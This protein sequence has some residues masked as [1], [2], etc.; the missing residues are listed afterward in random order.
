MIRGENAQ[1]AWQE[2]NFSCHGPTYRNLKRNASR[3]DLLTSLNEISPILSG[4]ADGIHH[5]TVERASRLAGGIERTAEGLH[6]SG[7]EKFSSVGDENFSAFEF[8]KS[9]FEK[10]VTFEIDVLENP[11]SQIVMATVSEYTSVLPEWLIEETFKQ[12]ALKFPGKI[13]TAWLLK[14]AALGIVEHTNQ[15]DLVNAVK[16]LNEPVQRILSKQ[17]GK[18]LAN[19]IALAIATSI[20]KKILASSPNVL[21]VKQDLVRLRRI[22]KQAKGGLGGALLT[23]LGSQGILQKAAV[24]SR[25][26][27]QH[28]PRLWQLLRFKLNGANM[29]YFLIESMIEEYVDRLSLLEQNPREFAKV[30]EALIRDKKTQSVYFP[31]S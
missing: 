5:Q 14:A 23:L 24:A 11:V 28:C 4:V 26:L 12:G 9:A 2:C 3:G 8:A 25:R 21:Q 7:Q 6:L 17:L 15:D 20:T 10:L 18:K 30:M 19:A 22:G 31:G 29:I 13:D 16:L 27:Q 1:K